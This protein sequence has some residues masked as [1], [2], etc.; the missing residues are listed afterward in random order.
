MGLPAFLSK[1]R[2]GITEA[3]LVAITN[4]LGDIVWTRRFVV[5]QGHVVP[6]VILFQDN[7]SA[8]ALCN[9]GG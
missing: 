3:E 8:I 4:T 6:S 2:L 1:K 9:R 7:M 5:D